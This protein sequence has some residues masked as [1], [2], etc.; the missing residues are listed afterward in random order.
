M[1]ELERIVT[2]RLKNRGKGRLQEAHNVTER[3]FEAVFGSVCWVPR[4]SKRGRKPKQ[5][6]FAP[7]LHQRRAL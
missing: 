3:V 5:V 6:L 7:H 1:H 2:G 4:V